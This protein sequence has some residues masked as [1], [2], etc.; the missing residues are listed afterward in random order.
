MTLAT[1][2][3]GGLDNQDQILLRQR[4]QL[5]ESWSQSLGGEVTHS[6]VTQLGDTV[7]FTQPSVSRVSTLCVQTNTMT[8]YCDF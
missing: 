7:R 4:P 3:L 1:A 5:L 8:Y 6:Q 2:A